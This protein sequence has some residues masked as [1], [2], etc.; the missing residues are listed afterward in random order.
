MPKNQ[1]LS[2]PARLADPRYMTT[3]ALSLRV[4]SLKEWIR[5]TKTVPT[6]LNR[7]KTTHMYGELA[8]TVRVLVGRLEAHRRYGGG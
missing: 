6:A 1:K 2:Y 4:E 5:R 7:A 8:A 3:E